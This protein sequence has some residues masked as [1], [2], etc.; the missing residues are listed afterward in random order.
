MNNEKN[1]GALVSIILFV[2]SIIFTFFMKSFIGD[3]LA[4][5]T[6]I[7]SSINLKRKNTLV[8]VSFIGSILLIIYSIIAFIIS[9]NV[10]NN[11][12]SSAKIDSYKMCEQVIEDETRKYV[13]SNDLLSS[14]DEDLIFSKSEITNSCSRC[15]GY[16]IVKTDNYTYNAYLKCD[17][18]KTDGFDS[19]TFKKSNK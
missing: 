10:I 6:L 13:E 18:Y 2:L 8:I 17:N 19:Q 1:K 7:V 9:F 15:D 14:S 3:I 5:I 12:L 11:T 4:I 16:I